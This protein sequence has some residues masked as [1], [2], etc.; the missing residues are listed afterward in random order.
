MKYIKVLTLLSCFATNLVFLYFEN[1]L[2]FMSLVLAFIFYLISS[3]IHLVSHECGHLI[4]GLLTKYKLLFL[5]LGPCNVMMKNGRLSFSWRKTHGGQC[6]MY[7]EQ[8]NGN[9]Y[10]AYNLGGALANIVVSLLGFL[11]LVPN[12]F[13]FSLL[14]I[15]IVIVGIQKVVTNLVPH[16]TNSIP[17]DGYIVKLLKNNQAIQQDYAMYLRLYADLFLEKHIS[18]NDYQ[19]KRKYVKDAE[20]LMYYNE[21]Q[22]MLQSYRHT[23]VR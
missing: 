21:L 8:V 6:V 20:E 13:N 12:T 10:K 5:Q 16:K 15:E 3:A 11:L 14:F 4:G 1:R 18:I 2:S 23:S 7:P 22:E 17:N 19:Y 9:C